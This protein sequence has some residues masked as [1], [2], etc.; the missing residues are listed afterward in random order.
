[1]GEFQIIKQKGFDRIRPNPCY[2]WRDRRNLFKSFLLEIP[3][4][5]VEIIVLLKNKGI[6][7][8]KNVY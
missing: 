4:E 8:S 1:M 5:I 7:D 2:I 3:E 6:H